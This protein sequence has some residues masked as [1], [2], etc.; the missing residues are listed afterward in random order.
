MSLEKEKQIKPKESTKKEIIEIR[1]EINEV[2]HIKQ[3][4]YKAK[5][6]HF[7]VE[8]KLVS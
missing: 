8:D 3:R 5:S 2:T 4:T 7:F 1:V 6:S